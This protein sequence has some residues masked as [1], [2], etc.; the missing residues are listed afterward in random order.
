MERG[1]HLKRLATVCVEEFSVL[2]C[3]ICVCV[4]FES[5]IEVVCCNP[6]LCISPFV[7]LG[8]KLVFHYSVSHCISVINLSVVPLSCV[9]SVF[10]CSLSS[11][12]EEAYN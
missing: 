12:L 6:V 7:D 4:L 11:C 9:I 3:K 5:F 2:S 10:S 1:N 8:N